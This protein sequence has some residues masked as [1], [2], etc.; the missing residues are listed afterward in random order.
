MGQVI[1]RALSDLSSGIGEVDALISPEWSAENILTA[2]G[3]TVLIQQN[4]TM[5]ALFT[6]TAASTT[7]DSRGFSLNGSYWNAGVANVSSFTLVNDVVN[8]STSLFSVRGTSDENLLTISNMGDTS[9]T[10][11]LTVGRRLYLGSK[12]TGEGSTSTYIFVDDTLS[13]TS[14]YIATNAD[15]WSTS[16]TYDYAERFASNETL[17]NG[18]IVVADPTGVDRVKR[19]TSRFDVILGIV[20]TKPGFVTGAPNPGTFPIALAGRVPTRVSTANGTITAGDQLA[21]SDVPGV[22]V[23]ATNAGPVIGIALDSYAGAEEGK[24]SVF[25]QPG[26]KGDEIVTS[27][28]GAGS[29][30]VVSSNNAS[31]RQGLAKIYAGAME[32]EVTFDTLNAYPLITVTPYGL[33]T[34]GWGLRDV[35]DHGFTLVLSE[36]QTFDLTFAWKAE[37]S[38]TGDAMSFSDGTASSY[39]PTSGLIFGPELPPVEEPVS[40]STTTSTPPIEPVAPTST[41]PVS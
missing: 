19:S 39:D 16:S 29:V 17:L 18:D 26:W 9:I 2:D 32:V 24:I 38:Q 12:S 1:G 25:V 8:A 33:P 31:P 10:G 35:T 23:K 41:E 22:A 37:A 21:P 27:G 36:A 11:D 5:N 3:D 4:A 14:T 28:P 13:P 15:G 7:A 20:S 6:S 40:A 34:G 30:T